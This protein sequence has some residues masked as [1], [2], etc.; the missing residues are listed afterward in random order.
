MSVL[1]YGL[2]ACSVNLSNMRSLEIT[3]K[4]ILIKLFRTYYNVIIDSCMASR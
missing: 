1:V 3:V 4:R 2:D